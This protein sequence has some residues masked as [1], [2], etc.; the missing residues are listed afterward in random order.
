MHRIRH[1]SKR[2]SHL[3]LWLGLLAAVGV[4]AGFVHY[5][6]IQ[7]EKKKSGNYNYLK[8]VPSDSV[9]KSKLTDDQYRVA[10]QNATETAFRNEYWDNNRPGIYVDVITNDPLFS[11]LDK[12]DAGT[13]RP[14]FTK[15]ISP[16]SVLQQADTSHD[17]Q[18]TEV[19]AKLSNSHLGHLFKDAT[20]PTGERY[21][22]NSAA[23]R[24]V[25]TDKMESEGYTEYLRPFEEK[26]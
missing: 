15:P 3:T 19:R 4:M 13:G 16:D 26:E 9:L 22:V 2:S 8:A 18:R 20:S 10:R 1:P 17:M 7:A 25:P 6:S 12:I 11:S 23:L 21:A 24:F 14:T 5:S